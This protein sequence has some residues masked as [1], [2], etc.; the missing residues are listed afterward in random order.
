MRYEYGE[1]KWI[2]SSKMAG[3]IGYVKHANTDALCPPVNG[4]ADWRT[5]NGWVEDDQIVVTGEIFLSFIEST[6]FSL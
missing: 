3:P 6:L 5:G 2:F 1:R 4:Y